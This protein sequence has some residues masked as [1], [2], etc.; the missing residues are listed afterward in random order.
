MEGAEDVSRVVHSEPVDRAR[1]DVAGLLSE[2]LGLALI[3]LALTQ[4]LDWLKQ[5]EE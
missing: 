4:M 2:L 5:S 3:L 1:D